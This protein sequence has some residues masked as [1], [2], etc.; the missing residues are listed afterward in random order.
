MAAC[1]CLSE[2][3]QLTLK[4]NTLLDG[5][6]TSPEEEYLGVMQFSWF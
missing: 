6:R 2:P 5:T 1:F 4:T 3:V